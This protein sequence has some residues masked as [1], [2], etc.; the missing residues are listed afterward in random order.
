MGVNGDVSTLLLTHDSDVIQSATQRRTDPCFARDKQKE[1]QQNQRTRRRT[2]E[3]REREK[4]TFHLPWHINKRFV[5]VY[6][7]IVS[8]VMSVNIIYRL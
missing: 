3:E 5:D 2:E 6:T 1:K 8:A 4:E 7:D